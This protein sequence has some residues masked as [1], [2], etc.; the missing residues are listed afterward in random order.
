MKNII[1][2]IIAIL[3]VY[4]I[5]LY[6]YNKDREKEPKKLLTKLFIYGMLACFPA[7]ILELVL[8]YFFN[9][10]EYMN[11]FEMFIYAIINIALVEELCKWFIVYNMTYHNSEFDHLY[12]MVVYSIFTSLGFAVLENILY[13]YLG[14]FTVG[15]FRAVSA[16]PGHASYAIIMANYLGKA[17]VANL[18]SD[19]H[20]E[21][22]NLLLS[23]L[24]PTFAHGLYD[25]FLFTDKFI[26]L[27]CYIIFLIIIYKYSQNKINYLSNIKDNFN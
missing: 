12:D 20:N 10:E 5:G 7:V 16:I 2:L 14:G 15:L 17:K 22:K 13:V 26:L 3:P 25:Y 18:N 24:M 9:E 27:I 23:I 4:L 11:L 21:K 19:M 6:V 8:G 1:L